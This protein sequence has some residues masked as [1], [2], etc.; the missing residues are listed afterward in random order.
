MLTLPLPA[1][2]GE[3]PES[4]EKLDWNSRDGR[5]MTEIAL[6][7]AQVLFGVMTVAG[8][9]VAIAAGQPAGLLLVLAGPGL[10]LAMAVYL[11]RMGCELSQHGIRIQTIPTA[12]IPWANAEVSFRK[13]FGSVDALCVRDITKTKPVVVPQAT[14][15]RGARDVRARRLDQVAE[16]LAALA[17]DARGPTEG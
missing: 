2:T 6:P 16:Q 9:V 12:T 4:W 14:R 5:S 1:R 7:V 17:A 3:L 8:C 13:T 11:P 15:Q 10:L